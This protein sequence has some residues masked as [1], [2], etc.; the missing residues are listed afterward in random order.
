[1]ASSPPSPDH[2]DLHFGNDDGDGAVIRGS[3]EPIGGRAILQA[4]LGDQWLCSLTDA[5]H[6]TLDEASRNT[7]KRDLRPWLRYLE[8]H[9]CAQPTAATVKAFID[10]Q[11][12]RYRTNTV[13]NRLEAVMRFYR[14]C[15]KRGCYPNIAV[16]L[17]RDS[18][19]VAILPDIIHQADVARKVLAMLPAK[20]LID[21]RNR[22][23]IGLIGSGLETIAVHRACVGDIDLDNGRCRYA[24]RGHSQ[25]D[26]ELVLA[27]EVLDVVR[28]FLAARSA[29]G[30]CPPDAPLVTPI[31]GK[32]VSLSTL[33]MRLLVRRIADQIGIGNGRLTSTALRCAATGALV[34]R[35]G[36]DQAAQA[37]ACN[38][39]NLRRLARR[40]TPVHA[41]PA[42]NPSS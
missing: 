14:W 20:T 34:S 36:I 21:L 4:R 16:G 1:M 39:S 38:R 11:A 27:G 15:A 32:P 33:S 5:R 30:P 42:R 2:A 13:N 26:A 35:I 41:D 28:R 22:V 24:P 3:P 25:K 12:G 23:I 19:R 6:P 29:A 40:L 7:F 31:N 8:A 10:E 9:A 18:A 17:Y 37:L